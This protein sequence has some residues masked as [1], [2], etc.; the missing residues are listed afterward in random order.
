MRERG[1]ETDINVSVLSKQSDVVSAVNQ[2]GKGSSE[3]DNL[4]SPSEFCL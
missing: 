2:E 4:S 3:G 1:V